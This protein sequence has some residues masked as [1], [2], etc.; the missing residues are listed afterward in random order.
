M[1]NHTIPVFYSDAQVHDACSYSQSPLKPGLMAR[2][3][4]LD[5]AFEIKGGL[6]DAVASDRLALTHDL[7]HVKALIAGEKADGFGNK[8]KKDNRA[9]RTTVG[10]YLAAAEWAVA[11]KR[12]G[13]EADIIHPGAV[14]S[15]TS[16][17]HHA[18]YDSCEGFCT[19]NALNLAAAEL[20]KYRGINSM[21]I[22]GD[23]HYGNGCV[24]IIR[25]CDQTDYLRYIQLGIDHGAGWNPSIYRAAIE[26]AIEAHN[27]GLIMYQAGADAWVGDPLGGFLTMDE[28][29]ARDLITLQ[30][31]KQREIPIVVNLAGGYAAHYEDTLTIHLNTG[32]AMKEV[33]LGRGCATV[34]AEEMVGK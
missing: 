27:P 5:P 30:A 1:T 15:L 29:Y 6:I 12:E 2:K 11:G 34:K 17:F 14:W 3:I 26:K 24:D 18:G 4:A 9:I 20:S 22:D 16:G 8:S 19:F 31:A 28:L 23:A 33:F 13:G 25:R 7:G 32:E 21:I 10:N